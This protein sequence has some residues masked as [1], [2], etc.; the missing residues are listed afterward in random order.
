MRPPSLS[1]LA[2]FLRY[3]T[4]SCSSALASSQPLTSLNLT[5][6]SVRDR[7]SLFFELRSLNMDMKL[8][9]PQY[10]HRE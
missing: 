4:T 7:K 3:S 5:L 9:L 6:L 8:G 2:G 1:N 10:T